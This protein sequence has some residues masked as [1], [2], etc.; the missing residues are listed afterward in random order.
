MN[1]LSKQNAQVSGTKIIKMISVTGL[2][3]YKKFK[4]RYLNVIE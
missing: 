1:L 2:A 4:A 3:G